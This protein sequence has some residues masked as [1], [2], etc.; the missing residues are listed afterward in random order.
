VVATGGCFDLVHAGHVRFLAAARTL[1]DCLVVCLNSDSSVARLK[2]PGRPLQPAVDRRDV[3]LALGCVD[4][5]V[6][7]DD[8]TPITSLR[9]LR[10]DVFAKGADYTLDRIPEAGVLAEWG[11]QAVLLPYLEG[12]STSRLV[13]G[14]AD[15][16]GAVGAA[17]AGAAGPAG[18]VGSG[19]V[20]AASAARA[21]GAA[22]V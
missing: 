16:M 17:A 2:G 19:T 12:R 15:A 21:A 8:D 6:V 13:A 10:P 11:G 18:A 20:D 14:A 7:F 4:A 1:G 5:V 9:A 22:G 3:L